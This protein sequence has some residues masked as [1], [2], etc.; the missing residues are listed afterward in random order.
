V[1]ATGGCTFS[2]SCELFL[3]LTTVQLYMHA[4]RITWLEHGVGSSPWLDGK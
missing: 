4:A 3:T 1:S 2:T